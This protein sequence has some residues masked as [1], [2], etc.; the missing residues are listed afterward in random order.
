MTSRFRITLGQL[1]PTVG[2]L[3][4]NAD[5][6]REAWA[7]GKEAGADLVALPEM[8]LAGYN[9]QDL[10]MK[11]AFQLDV[12]TH[13]EALAA[14]CAD[15]PAL[16]IGAPWVEGAKLYNAYL[17]LRNGKIA[18]RVFKHNLPNETVFDEVRIFDSAPLGGPYAVG[19]TRIGS[20]ICEDAWH[21]DVAETLA[22]TGAEFL[23]VP[24]GSP[25]YR[26]KFET[27][28]N[29]MV[30]RVVET[31]LPLIY[32]NMVGGQDDQVF[33]GASFALNPGGKLAFQMP[34]FDAQIAHV[35]L[36]QTPEG[37]RVV[38]GEKAHMPSDLEQDYRV[39]VQGLRD[40]MGKT[41][42]KKVLL[43][44]SGGIDSA[45]VATIAV[46]ALGAD[47]VRC[48]MLPSE[49]TSQASLDDAESVAKALG[50]R[51]DY[52]PIAQGRAAITDT[53]APLF[54]G[55]TPDLTEENIQSR[56]RGLLLMAV[57]NKFGEMLLTTGNKSEVAVGY[58]T[59][60]GDMA[61]GYNPIKDMYKTRVFD[62]CRWRNENHR[63]WM[64]GPE[65]EVIAPRIIDKPPS[66]ELREDQKDSDSLPDYPDLDAMLTILVDDDGSIADCVAAGFDREVAK[67]VEHLLYISE[68]KRF[69]SAPGPRLT[70][71][72]FWLDR[73]Y[74]IVNRWRDPS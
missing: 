30:A 14:D 39:M 26:G 67:K 49:Y 55:T 56:L 37:W 2:D 28:L 72:A 25:Y 21:P 5:L 17:I 66:A 34:A 69:Q 63:D 16:A 41:G 71:G 74:P 23:L 4:G 54:D 52:V 62:S 15:G 45:I 3:A 65:G 18:S 36:E 48:V 61:G 40:Y 46:D 35:D 6:A 64:K 11:Q 60:Y 73:R 43:G 1:N 22:E 27:R 12:M 9:A 51:Y 13:L 20:P 19:D 50:C 33:D 70:K 47:N 29:H 42:F 38:E 10:V 68:Y 59:I 7:Q 53:L 58:A 57:S 31:E 44:L 8:F 24:N 32:L